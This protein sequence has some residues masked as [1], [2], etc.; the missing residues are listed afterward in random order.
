MPIAVTCPECQFAFT[1]A[2]E[3][4]GRQGRCPECAAVITV[5]AAAAPNPYDTP[6]YTPDMVDELRRSRATPPARSQPPAPPP[7][8]RPPSRTPPPP[9]AFDP[10]ARAERWRRVANGYRNLILA[11]VLNT[12]GWGIVSVYYSVVGIEKFDPNKFDEGRTAMDIGLY[13]VTAIALALWTLGRMAGRATP[14]VPARGTGMVG[15][16][17]AVLGGI[18]G[19]GGFIGLGVGTLIIRNNIN[20]GAGIGALSIMALML[21]LLCVF[22]AEIFCLLSQLKIA[23]ALHDNAFRTMTKV[24]LGAYLLGSLGLF[25]CGCMGFV[26]ISAEAQ[27][28]QQQQLA[29]NKQGPN[30]KNNNG[31]GGIQPDDNDNEP[32]DK[33]A[34]PKNANP[35][36]TPKVAPPPKNPAPK[37]NPNGKD[38]PKDKDKDAPKDKDKDAPKDKDNDDPDDKDAPQGPEI[39]PEKNRIATI[40]GLFMI[41]GCVFVFAAMYINCARLGRRAIQREIANLVGTDPDQTAAEHHSYGA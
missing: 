5:P 21:G 26:A 32:N 12:F 14:Y 16:V 7:L 19:V 10:H 27:R 25:F 1:V 40:I 11:A 2:D 9:P 35:K 13:V 33:N 23:D 28:Q 22:V 6:H 20:A 3:F 29:K 31:N 30:A 36:N 24:V 4:G 17:G 18:A 38:A 15:A 34:N 8:P 37:N 39:D 41:F